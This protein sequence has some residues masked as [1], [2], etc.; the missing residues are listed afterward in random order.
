MYTFKLLLLIV[1]H[2]L[3]LFFL[4]MGVWDLYQ[5]DAFVQSLICIALY[6]VLREP[7]EECEKWLAEEENR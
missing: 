4:F 6:L 3:R 2:L 5:K 7:K 1:V